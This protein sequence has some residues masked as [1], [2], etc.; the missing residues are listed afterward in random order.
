MPCPDASPWG[1]GCYF[2]HSGEIT[3]W[4]ASAL[5]DDE[6]GVLAVARSVCESQQVLPGSLSCMVQ[7]GFA[8]TLVLV[9][10]LRTTARAYKIIAREAALDLL[11]VCSIQW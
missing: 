7:Y 6:L 3:H 8:Q 9:P 5:R 2:L 1:L 4:F 11:L 10:H